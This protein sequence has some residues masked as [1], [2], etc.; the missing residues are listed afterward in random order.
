MTHPYPLSLNQTLLL[1]AEAARC[2]ADV[3]N[4]IRSPKV[5]LPADF[6]QRCEAVV[7]AMPEGEYECDLATAAAAKST[8]AILNRMGSLMSWRMQGNA[9]TPDSAN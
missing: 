9:V 4:S 1:E 2:L 8:A 3:I 7:N 5:P 6:G